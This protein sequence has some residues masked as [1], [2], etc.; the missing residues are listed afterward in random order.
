MTKEEFQK[1]ADNALCEIIAQYLQRTQTTRWAQGQFSQIVSVEKGLRG[2]VGEDFVVK[3]LQFVGYSDAEKITGRSSRLQ[4]TGAFDI[5]A[6]EKR[7]EVKTASEDIHGNFQFNGIKYNGATPYDL[8]I[9][10]GI[11]PDKVFFRICKKGDIPQNLPMMAKNTPGTHK[12]TLTSKKTSDKMHTME[13]FAEQANKFLEAP[14][15]N[16]NK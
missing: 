9:L 10:V 4:T 12:W 3:M 5:L 7:I 16:K 2:E 6:N 11:A 14:S 15:A 8:L 1:K 13:D